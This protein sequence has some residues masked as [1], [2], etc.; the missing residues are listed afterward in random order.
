MIIYIREYFVTKLLIDRL[1][2]EA[3]NQN[4]YWYYVLLRSLS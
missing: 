1:N 4:K 2:I 3:M